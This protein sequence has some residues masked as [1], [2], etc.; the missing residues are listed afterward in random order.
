MLIPRYLIEIVF[1]VFLV[2]YSFYIYHYS[3]GQDYLISSL[4]IMAIAGIRML[5]SITGISSSLAT[6]NYSKHALMELYEDVRSIEG[7]EPLD[8]NNE[9]LF[10][11]TPEKF[12]FLSVKNIDYAYPKSEKLA[13][14]K[15]S[16][17]LKEGE[18]IGLIGKSGS[19]KT[20][21]VD[22]LLGMYE[23]SNGSIIFNSN[24]LDSSNLKNW[25]NQVAYI[26]QS[27]FL[28]D[29]SLA[30]NVAFGVLPSLI[31]YEKVYEA[32]QQAQLT[33]VLARLPE[34]VFS[35][36][37]EKGVKLSGGEG[38]RVAIARALYHNRNVFIF[39]EAT[40]A[41]DTETEKNVVEM[42]ESL[43]GEKT[44]I[45]IAH[46]ISTL[47]HCDM[48]YKL[49]AGSIVKSGKFSEMFNDMAFEK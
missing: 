1:V 11:R 9:S 35:R 48:I 26:P 49:E 23:I 30:E 32:I 46:R 40:S 27:P 44:M 45:V 39:D 41:L 10:N 47:K 37:G 6:I 38:Q 18:S 36:L 34:G 8:E 14:N 22:L 25:L 20:T 2:L 28:I 12:Q 7:N 17:E 13:I 33:E 15:L 43:H 4:A 16:I 19:G 29:A 42:I 3:V 5:P 21:L 24:T 31:N